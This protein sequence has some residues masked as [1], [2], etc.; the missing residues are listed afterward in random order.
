MNLDNFKNIYFLGIGGIGMSALARYFNFKGKNIA[1]YD[2]TSSSLTQELEQE[3]IAIHYT[4]DVQLIPNIFLDVQH[5]LVVITPAIPSDSIEWDYFKTGN[6]T[7]KKRAEILGIITQNNFTVGVAGTH[8]KTTTSSMLAHLLHIGGA[9][10]T[11]FLG[12]IA[13]NYNSN[14]LL[15]KNT[16]VVEADEYDRSFLQLYPDL[17]IITSVDADHLDIYGTKEYL[18]ESFELYVKQLKEESVLISKLGLDYSIRENENTAVFFYSLS[19]AQADFYAQNL[20]I[21]NGHYVFDFV[22]CIKNMYNLKLGMAGLHNVENAIAA[23]AAAQVMEIDTDNIKEALESFQGVKRRFDYQLKTHSKVMIDDYA[24]HPEEIKALI[25]SV[26]ELYPNK[27]ITGIFQPHL[28]SR[29]KDFLTEFA[30]ELSQLNH[31]ILLPIYPAR[32]KP[33][34]GIN[35]EKLLELI[36]S[37]KKEIVTLENIVSHINFGEVELLL[38]IGAGNIDTVVP[39]LKATYENYNG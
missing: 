38:T 20:R 7:I 34:E 27:K 17:A 21:E 37:E 12:G 8:G 19:D 2:K 24:H 16:V 5:T 32:E 23:I 22:S 4:D 13:S 3:N 11:A 18:Q 31:C 29:T 36:Q 33:I 30:Q 6:F 14:L 10:P 26:K 1:G 25:H 39:L 28:F 35:S 15:G 9:Q